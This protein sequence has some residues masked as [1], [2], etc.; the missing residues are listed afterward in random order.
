M[1]AQKGHETVVRALIKAG[2]DINNADDDGVTPLY[3]AVQNG[4]EAV[5]R[6]L[7]ELSADV[8]KARDTGET[9]LCIAAHNGYET[10]VRALIEAGAD[11]NKARNGATPL[12]AAMT[13]V[14]NV[15]RGNHEAI[16]QILRDAGA[17]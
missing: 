3:M 1:A 13:P 2:A 10:V 17:V 14:P 15:A 7:I 6:V 11:V 16:V 4:H 5:V 12:S 9:P 8:N